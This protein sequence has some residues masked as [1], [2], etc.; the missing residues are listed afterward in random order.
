MNG[1]KTF[2]QSRLIPKKK[3]HT[4]TPSQKKER[5]AGWWFQTCF[6]SPH[7]GED[8]HFDYVFQRGLKPP[9]SK[10]HDISLEMNRFFVSS[11]FIF[12]GGR[13]VVE[14]MDFCLP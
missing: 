7:I 5:Q 11:L 10:S 2:L 14:G 9:T 3:I 1:S 6:F 4:D 8:S 13:R 12:L